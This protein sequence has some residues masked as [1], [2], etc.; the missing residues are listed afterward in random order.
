MNCEE[1]DKKID[2]HQKRISELIKEQTKN[3][4][5]QFFEFQ[6]ESNAEIENKLN[7]LRERFGSEARLDGKV[8]E[9]AFDDFFI[10]ELNEAK[11]S[12]DAKILNSY[13]FKRVLYAFLLKENLDTK[14]N[15]VLS[16]IS[17]KNR[18]NDVS[19]LLDND[20]LY[21]IL[22]DWIEEYKDIKDSY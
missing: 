20:D 22:N 15:D 16:Y 4:I 14:I 12:L 5:F 18:D 6:L 21:D 7:K 19:L 9:D 2:D 13:E 11:A 8:N 17:E 3:L 1:L 10:S